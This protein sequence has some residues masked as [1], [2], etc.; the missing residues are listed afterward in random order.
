M[1]FDL[2]GLIVWLRHE[3]FELHREHIRQDYRRIVAFHNGME[4]VKDFV[5]L[6]LA[7]GEKP[8]FA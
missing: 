3:V 2:P 1:H 6:E 5:D 4:T 7:L 8:V